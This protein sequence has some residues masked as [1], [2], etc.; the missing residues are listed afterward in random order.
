MP[1]RKTNFGD[2]LFQN[3]NQYGMYLERLTELAISM[4]EWKNLPD[5][6]DERFLELTLFTN[7]YAVFFK[8]EDLINTGLS[9]SDTGSYLALPVATNGRWNVYNIPT[10]RRAYASNGYNKNLD[11][12]NSVVIY[13]NLLHTNSINISRT[14]ARRLYNLD[15]IVDVNANAQK[16]PVLILANEQQ[17]LTMLQVY[18]KWDGNEPVIF[19][20][21]DLDMKLIQALR[22]DAPYVADKI[23]SLKTELWN[24]ALTYLGISNI[25]FQKKER[26]ISDEVL[27]NQG[28]TIASRYSRLN[29]R[30]KAA[31]EINKMFGLNIEVDFR[32]DYREADDEIMF[33]GQTGTEHDEKGAI[34]GTPVAI[35]LRTK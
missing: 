31:D 12:N 15:R 10:K 29:A 19:G 21:R 30:R 11:V 26:M 33:Q 9:D 8:D 1:R 3:N 23:Q 16:T 34:S 7:G 5:S 35:D 25:S 32:E 4:F 18:Q 20:D 24:E 27:R 28:G 6:C 13:N 22:T 14:Y 2:S 17:R